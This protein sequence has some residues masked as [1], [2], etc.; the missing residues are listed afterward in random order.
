MWKTLLKM[1]IKCGK[2][3]RCALFKK[4]VLHFAKKNNYFKKSVALFKKYVIIIM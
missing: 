2:L 1:W 4:K 3:K